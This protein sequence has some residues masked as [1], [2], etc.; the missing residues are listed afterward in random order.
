MSDNTA[1]R[2]LT[3]ITGCLFTSVMWQE[4]TYESIDG[5]IGLFIN[6]DPEQVRKT[7]DNNIKIGLLQDAMI[8]DIS[9]LYSMTK[10]RK[11]G[12][13]EVLETIRRIIEIVDENQKQWSEGFY[14]GGRSMK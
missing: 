2:L 9:G 12:G 7:L 1:Q 6:Q 11:R 5:R 3:G 4:I 13:H 14:Y 10:P 8:E